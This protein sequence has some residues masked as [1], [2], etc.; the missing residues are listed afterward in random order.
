M[1]ASVVEVIDNDSPAAL[2]QAPAPRV[3]SGGRGHL[4]T[5]RKIPKTP[6]S[7]AGRG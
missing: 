5:A 3:H 2:A 7:T 6:P 4:G 1:T